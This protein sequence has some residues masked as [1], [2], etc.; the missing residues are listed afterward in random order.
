R[1][2]SARSLTKRLAIAGCVLAAA[3]GA[4]A[5]VGVAASQDRYEAAAVRLW[6]SKGCH[7][8]DTSMWIRGW[9]FNALF[10]SCRAADGHDQRVWFF[11]RGRFVGTGGSGWS[12]EVLGVWRA[13][14]TLAFIYVLY[15]R[16]DPLCCPTGG[17]EIVRF[18][19]TGRRF[20]PL[21]PI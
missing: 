18:R 13:D 14:T 8:P 7:A 20:K 1:V 11:D 6:H 12:N 3:M 9:R 15:R 16:N 4:G 17:G 19:W 2:A 10:G 21:D 5:R